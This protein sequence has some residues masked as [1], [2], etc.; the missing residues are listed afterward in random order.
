M[1]KLLELH[2]CGERKTPWPAPTMWHR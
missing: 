2:H 1:H